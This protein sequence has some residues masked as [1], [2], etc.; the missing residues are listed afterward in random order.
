MA[1]GRDRLT[2]RALY[3]TESAE[4]PRL[5]VAR[6]P[7]DGRAAM[8]QATR[9]QRREL[10]QPGEYEDCSTEYRAC[11]RHL[12]AEKAHSVHGGLQRGRG[13]RESAPDQKISRSE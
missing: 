1:V 11:R 3:R 12:H 7:F 4:F 6:Q 9:L 13:D 5:P 2:S 10:E 8:G